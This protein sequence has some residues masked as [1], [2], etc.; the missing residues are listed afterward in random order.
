MRGMLELDGTSK[1]MEFERKCVTVGQESGCEVCV[2]DEARV[3][4]AL[5]WR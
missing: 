3:R 5:V 4:Q 2:E 1:V